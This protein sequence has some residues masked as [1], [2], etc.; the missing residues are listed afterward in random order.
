MA[1]FATKCKC[2]LP[3][4]ERQIGELP[5]MIFA[6]EG[7]G[8]QRKANVVREFYTTNQI[9]MWTRGGEQKNPKIL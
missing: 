1:E 3:H 2:R 7:G 5:N 6:F 4:H 8:D 9:L